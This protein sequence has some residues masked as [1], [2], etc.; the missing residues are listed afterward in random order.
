MPYEIVEVHLLVEFA[1]ILELKRL[2]LIASSYEF[3]WQVHLSD[4]ASAGRHHVAG[5]SRHVRLDPR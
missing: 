4:S 1:L 3:G 5:L 2:K